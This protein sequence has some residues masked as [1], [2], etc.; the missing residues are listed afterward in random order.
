MNKENFRRFI[1]QNKKKNYSMIVIEH[2]DKNGIF[3]DEK[4]LIR[5]DNACRRLLDASYLTYYTEIIMKRIV[6]FINYDAD[7]FSIRAFVGSLRQVLYTVNSNSH[8]YVFYSNGSNDK[9]SLPDMLDYVIENSAY[10]ILL[11]KRRPVPISYIYECNKSHN[12]SPL[13]STTEYVE[14]LKNKDIDT[15]KNEI[16]QCAELLDGPFSKENAFKLSDLYDLVAKTYY[17]VEIFFTEKKYIHPFYSSSLSECFIKYD[18]ISDILK[19]IASALC[20]YIEQFSHVEISEKKA[21]HMKEIL[22]YI[23]E[24]LATVSLAN[25]SI[26][27]D[28]TP[29]Y[30]CRLF[31][32]EYSTNFTDYIKKKRFDSAVEILTSDS[33]IT[34]TELCKKIGYQSQSYFQNIFKKEFGI[35]PDSYRKQYHKNH[36]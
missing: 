18:G 11:G 27:F 36:F 28:L 2:K 31:K 9:N 32:T 3:A 20:D 30:I 12:S 35:T 22:S 7:T 29:A 23:D 16:T 8:S 14:K 33:K 17:L 26:H 1:L 6:Y 24:N 5:D 15:L 19:A 13:F 25:I 34:I 10:S 21:K 4:D